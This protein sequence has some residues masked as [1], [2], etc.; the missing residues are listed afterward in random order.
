MTV[1]RGFNV[2]AYFV[3]AVTIVG[4]CDLMFLSGATASKL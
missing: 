1:Y 2:W 4:A 3:G